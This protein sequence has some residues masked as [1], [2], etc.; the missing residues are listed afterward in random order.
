M[1]A[2]L[3]RGRRVLLSFG[4]ATVVVVVRRLPVVMGGGLVMSG[5]RVMVLARGVFGRSHFGIS[6][7]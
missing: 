3:V 1:G 7:M 2:V 5:R 4:M 6:F